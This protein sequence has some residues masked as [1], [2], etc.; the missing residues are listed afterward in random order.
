MTNVSDRDWKDLTPDERMDV[1]FAN[2]LNVDMPFVSDE[3]REAYRARAQR[4]MDAAR[5]K[6]TPD[7]VPY[8]FL[9]AEVYPATRAGLLPYDAMYD[10]FNKGQNNLTEI[11]WNR[12]SKDGRV[13]DPAHFGDED[14]HCWNHLLEDTT[15]Q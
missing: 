6:K 4:L 11:K 3:A 5:L 10:I 2:W 1:R 13:K 12:T 8:P 15:C 9:V 14:W 7:R